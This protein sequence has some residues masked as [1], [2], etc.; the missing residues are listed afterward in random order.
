MIIGIP[1]EIMHGERRVSAIPETVQKLIHDVAHLFRLHAEHI[2]FI[3]QNLADH[4]LLDKLKGI[5]QIACIDR[6]QLIALRVHKI[7]EIAVVIRILHLL[8]LN[9]SGREFIRGVKGAL[10]DGAGN[11]VAD[12]C[13]HKGRALAGLYML[14]FNDL[15][16]VSVHLKR[17]AVSE[18]TC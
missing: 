17:N 13:A 11:H 4:I 16:N 1:K 6:D 9:I 12:F 10:C 3:G 7:I 5:R 15:I 18:I 14:E 2:A 8:A